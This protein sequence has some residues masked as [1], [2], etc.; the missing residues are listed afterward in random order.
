MIYNEEFE[1]MPRE[2]IKVLQ[3]KR[4]QQVL[5]RVYHTVGFYKKSFDDAKVK[6]DDIKTIAD[7]K[8]L[9]FT[10]RKNLRDN[11]PFGLFA[12]PMSSV[13]RLHASSGTSG[14]SAVFGYTKHD[15]EIWSDLIARSLVAAGITKND[16]IH[17]AF[18]YGLFTGGLA[19]HYGAEK[20][21]ASV[22]PMSGGDT[23]RQL[24]ILQDFGPTVICSLP[25]YAL[26]LAEE[27]KALGINMKSLKLRVGILGAEPW[28]NDTRE[29]IEKTLGIS[30]LDLYGLSEV[31]GPGMA[32]ECLEGREG[33]HIF[34]D[35]F[36]VETINPKTGEVLPEGEEGELVYTSI[37]K[38]ANPIIRYRSGDISHLITKPCR[39]GRSH[40]RMERVSKRSDD[41][42]IIRGVN[43]FPSQIEAILVDIEGLN[44]QYQIVIDRVEALDTLDLQV[45]VNEKIFSDSGSVKELQK[46]EQ[47]I[48]KDMKDYLGISARVKLVEPNTLKTGAKIIDKRRF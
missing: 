43:V 44:P 35:H 21:G 27:G 15:I 6:P 33:M 1:T 29:E 36:I 25:S 16:I 40:V 13:V 22:I 18:G 20:I 23:K 38:E 7:M 11:Y 3:V 5:E 41:M 2:V 30:A 39:C 17:N 32:M 9:P 31:M 4:L 42:L 14:K 37:T 12:V 28:S 24:M 46:I 45:E 8:K 47:R 19:L 26:H 10:T 34:E 48:L